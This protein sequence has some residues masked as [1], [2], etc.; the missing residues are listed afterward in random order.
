MLVEIEPDAL[1]FQ[2]ISRTGAV[3]DAASLTRPG[4]TALS[5]PSGTVAPR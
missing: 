2:A 1:H 5:T 3:I 4:E